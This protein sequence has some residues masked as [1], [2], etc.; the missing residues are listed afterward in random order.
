MAAPLRMAQIGSNHGHA[1]GKWQAI[2][3]NPEVDAVAL[4]DP[5]D[6][7]SV[8]ADPSIVAVA[9]ETRNHQSLAAAERAIEGGKHLWYDKPAG[10]DLDAFLR[11]VDEAERRGLQVQMGYMFRYSPGF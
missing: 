3:T 10:D 4:V 7:D 11:I 5:A 9:I 2:R 8:L 6:A 1:A